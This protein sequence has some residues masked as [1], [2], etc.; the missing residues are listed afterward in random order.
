MAA[1]TNKK[2]YETSDI[3]VKKVI[4]IAVAVVLVVIVAIVALNE[5]F[6][7]LKEEYVYE[8]VLRPE[9]VTLRDLRAA[10]DEI[11]NSYKLVDSTAGVYRIPIERA[12]ELM[13][14]EAFQ[15]SQQRQ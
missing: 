15:A 5:Y 6:V 7:S 2:G 8:M 14:E 3:N 1:D 12:M 9:S 13:A 4:L 10:E 11:L